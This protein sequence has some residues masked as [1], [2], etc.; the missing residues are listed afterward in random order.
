MAKPTVVVVLGKTGVGKTTTVNNV[1]GASFV[2]SH[3][4]V[5]T[6]DAQIKEFRTATG[7]V[8]KIIDVPGYGRSLAEDKRSMK[9]YESVVPIADV[10]LLVIQADS[11]DMVDDQEM[12]IAVSRMLK[13]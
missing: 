7:D 6:T 13:G 5:G 4:L 11:R 2:T 8:L 9:I 10:V 3:T 1:F 12:V